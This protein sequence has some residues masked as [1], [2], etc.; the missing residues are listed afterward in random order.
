MS[1]MNVK[2]ELEKARKRLDMLEDQCIR[3]EQD[4]ATAV[5]R[6]ALTWAE[7]L[8]ISAQRWTRSRDLQR[9]VY[10][11]LVDLAEKQVDLVTEAAKPS[12]S[13]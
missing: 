8:R 5:E 11:E 12:K 2:V 9:K 1:G 3:A 7:Q 10:R 6:G 13:K 4:I